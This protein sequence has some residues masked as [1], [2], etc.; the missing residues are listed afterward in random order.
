MPGGVRSGGWATT[1]WPAD[2]PQ[3]FR[4]TRDF[5]PVLLA[6]RQTPGRG[7]GPG[8]GPGPGPLRPGYCAE[9]LF[10][11]P[12]TWSGGFVRVAGREEVRSRKLP[13]AVRTDRPDRLDQAGRVSRY[14]YTGSTTSCAF[15]RD[16][17]GD[18]WLLGNR[19]GSFTPR[20]VWCTRRP[21]TDAVGAISG[22]P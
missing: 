5:E 15:W 21:L 12:R 7:A 9:Q 1:W 14:Y 16:A 13:A 2:T 8:R 3:V 17:D 18:F 20:A 4:F 19:S 11:S 22:V 10:G 6:A